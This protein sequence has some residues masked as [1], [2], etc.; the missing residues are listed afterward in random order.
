MIGIR[1]LRKH[2][3]YYKGSQKSHFY[4]FEF[5][6]QKKSSKISTS[7]LPN[8]HFHGSIKFGQ[9]TNQTFPEKVQIYN[10]QTKC[11]TMYNLEQLQIIRKMLSLL[12]EPFRILPHSQKKKN[13]LRHESP[14]LVENNLCFHVSRWYFRRL[15]FALAP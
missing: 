9:A 13:R 15:D 8:N 12:S 6:T 4:Y 5:P 3:F 10:P 1:S 14:L 11:L 2:Q 7:Y